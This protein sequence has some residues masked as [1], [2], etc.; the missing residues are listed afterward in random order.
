M[1]KTVFFLVIIMLFFGCKEETVKEPDHLIDKEVMQNIIY[2]LS[3]LEAIK[4]NEPN[5][6]ENYRVNP[7][8]FIYRKYKID[9]AQFAQNNIYYASNFD[10][11]KAMYDNVIKRIDGKKAVIDAVLKKEAKRDSLIAQKKRTDSIQKVKK[12]ALVKKKDSLQKIKKKDSLLLL[13]KKPKAPK[14]I[15]TSIKSKVIK[16]GVRVN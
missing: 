12:I 6:T 8:E 9:S 1:K 2:D 10:E 15:S 14:K 3:L 4:Y 7:K 13:K 11:Y 5:T 16:N